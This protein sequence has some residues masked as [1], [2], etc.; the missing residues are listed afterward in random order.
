LIGWIGQVGAARVL[1][2]HVS[3]VWC[4]VWAVANP[5]GGVALFY[6]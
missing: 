2:N 3:G 5:C 1:A 6:R 4:R